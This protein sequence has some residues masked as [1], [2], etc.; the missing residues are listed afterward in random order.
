MTGQTEFASKA[1]DQVFDCF[2]KATESTLQVQQDLFR[3]WTASWPGF[4]KVQFP[5]VE[6]FQQFQKEWTQATADLTRKYLEVWERQYQAGVESLHGAFRA[7]E[8]KDPAE[9]RQK[10]MELW[11]KSFNCLKELA[12][13]QMRNAQSAVEKWMEV[14]KKAT[15]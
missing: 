7:G 14:A 10:M 8:A 2:R 15:P 1:F 12:E 4:P 3:Q 13:A 9:F 6:Q 5:L 11:Q